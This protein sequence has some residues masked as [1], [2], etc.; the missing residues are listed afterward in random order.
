M[1]PGELDAGTG[2]PLV[3]PVALRGADGLRWAYGFRSEARAAQIERRIARCG[4]DVIVPDGR[5]ASVEVR[6]HSDGGR[7]AWWGG[8]ARCQ[9]AACPVCAA[10]RARVR[11]ARVE[12]ALR[13]DDPAQPW[14]L[15][16]LTIPHGVRSSL[17]GSLARLHAGWRRVRATRRI[18]DVWGAR[19]SAS[20]RATELTW[21]GAHGWHPHIHLLVRGELAEHEVGELVE[22]WHRATGA[23]RKYGVV[24]SPARPAGHGGGRYLAKLGAEVAGAGKGESERSHWRILR[25]AVDGRGTSAGDAARELW[26][27]YTRGVKGRRLFEL[28]E[29]AAQLASDGA[30][31]DDEPVRSWSVPVDRWDLR[32]LGR[33]DSAD[34]SA[35]ALVAPLL[36][37]RS[38]V[39][40]EEAV[41][42]AVEAGVE[43]ALAELPLPGRTT[44]ATFGGWSHDHPPAPS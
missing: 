30:C 8:V 13:A 6:E 37:V 34:P 19:V 22:A 2:G 38:F 29:R 15:I 16:T 36:A 7:S 18:R 20:I 3:P 25:R 35:E 23:S 27:E 26:G 31:V 12:A 40:V 14:Q 28:D 9:R 44:R 11:C 4:M 42:M 33:L 39:G 5:S 43:T 32:L 1:R 41:T 17:K 24:V 21:S 10:R